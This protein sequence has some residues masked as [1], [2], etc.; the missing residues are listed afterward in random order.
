MGASSGT[1]ALIVALRAL[2]IGEGD[3]VITVANGPVP[4]IAA[5]RAVGARP[6]FVDVDSATLQMDASLLRAALRANTR[7]VIPLHLYGSAANVVEIAAFCH[8]TWSVH[9]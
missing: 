2:D 1:D 3:E 9:D 6:R 8:E 7:C 4:T 5:I